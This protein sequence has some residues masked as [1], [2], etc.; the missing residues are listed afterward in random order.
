MIRKSLT[1]EDE[2]KSLVNDLEEIKQKQ[3]TGG[4]SWIVYRTITSNN[5]DLFYPAGANGD[6]FARVTFTP[7]NP[8]V[9]SAARLYQM[10]RVPDFAQS[11]FAKVTTSSS[12]HEWVFMIGIN[13]FQGD[14]HIRFVVR[15]TH[16]GT[17][18]VEEI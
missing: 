9:E 1:I 17:L 13:G 11:E 18:T 4:D 14:I 16:R 3:L 5:P 7:E 12:K 2:V 10:Q 6:F 15:S 8:E